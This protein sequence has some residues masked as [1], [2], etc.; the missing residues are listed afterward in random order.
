MT[1]SPKRPKPKEKLTDKDQSERFKE[2]ARELC[3]GENEKSFGDVLTAILASK[4]SQLISKTRR[5]G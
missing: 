5:R 2:T 4:P 3:V 1:Q